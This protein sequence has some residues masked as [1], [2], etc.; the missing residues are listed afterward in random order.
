[1]GMVHPHRMHTKKYHKTYNSH[2]IFLPQIKTTP[3]IPQ[4]VFLF[5]WLFLTSESFVPSG[6]V[7]RYCCYV[8]VHLFLPER[9]NLSVFSAAHIIGIDNITSLQTVIGVLSACCT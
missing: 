2:N 6:I 9:R 3:F 7:R 8:L 4:F 5:L 1:M